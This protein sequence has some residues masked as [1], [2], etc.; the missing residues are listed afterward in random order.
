MN[1]QKRSTCTECE[2]GM[3][4]DKIENS[5][6]EIRLHGG[7]HVKKNLCTTCKALTFVE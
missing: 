7:L 2:A 3:E 5:T 6:S 4:V 1:S